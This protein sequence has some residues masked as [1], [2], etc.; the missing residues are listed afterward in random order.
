MIES[1]EWERLSLTTK[2]DV[3]RTRTQHLEDLE[4]ATDFFLLSYT[5][6]NGQ[7]K[8][9]RRNKKSGQLINKKKTQF[10]RINNKQEWPIVV[11][12]NILNRDPFI[13]L[14]RRVSEGG[15]T[16]DDIRNCINQARFALTTLWAIWCS[17]A[18]SLQNKIRI[19]NTYIESVLLYSSETWWVTHKKIFKNPDLCQVL[20]TDMGIK[21][22][23]KMSTV[24]L[25][26]RTKQKL[27]AQD[28]NQRTWSWLDTPCE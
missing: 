21:W 12:G 13:Y 1:W 18:L 27:I 28:I 3:Q 17:K 4:F 16:S 20:F 23:K 8:L 7:V 15:G 26:K 5:Q 24:D 6:Q 9:I 22:T 14:D 25:W 19:F 11:R 2:N 10:M